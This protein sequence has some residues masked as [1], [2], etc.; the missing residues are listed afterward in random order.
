[1]RIRWYGLQTSL[2]AV[3]IAGHLKQM[4]YEPGS[5]DGFVVHHSRPEFLE[6][7]LVQRLLTTHETV[8]PFGHEE[9]YEIV[10]YLRSH[11]RINPGTSSLE[12][13]DPGRA[14][15]R[16]VS[17]LLDALNSQFFIEEKNVDPLSWANRFRDIVGVYG[18]IERIQIGSIAIAE[19]IVGQVLAKGGG[20]IADAAIRF[21][22]PAGYLVEK[23]QL[24]FRSTRGSISFQRNSTVVLSASVDDLWMDALRSSLR[25]VQ[26]GFTIA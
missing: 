4:P 14:G 19:G 24:K 18:S 10:D 21:V 22:A 25:D 9:T 8:D 7:F 17:R 12:L 1:M 13:R 23:V 16:L 15:S 20:D 3:A 26:A 2:D 11:F 5:P 6:G